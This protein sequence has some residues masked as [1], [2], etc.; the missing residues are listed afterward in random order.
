MT[1]IRTISPDEASARLRKTYDRIK[2][3]DG[4]VDNIMTAHSLRPHTL[5]GH[6]TLYKYVLHH[7]GNTLPKVLVESIG[8][9]VSLLNGCAY[10]V[11]HHFAGLTRLLE[12]AGRAAAARDALEADRPELAFTGR[13]L[14]ALHY[15]RCLTVAPATMAESSI[16]DLR[17]SGFDDGE[18][19]EINQVVAYFAYANRTVLGLGITT[20]G[21]TLGLSPH[22]SDDPNDWSHR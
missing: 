2:G 21:D 9:Y 16:E 8:V 10:C 4:H 20:D 15:A 14:A 11:E 12:D 22:A 6:M 5:D 19:L 1:W 7:G 13:D 3:A 17:S 18:I